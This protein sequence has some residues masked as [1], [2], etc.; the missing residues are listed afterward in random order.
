MKRLEERL[1]KF[2]I[3][4]GLE[5][6]ERL[7]GALG[8]PQDR[9]DVVLVTGTNGKGSV[10][11]ALSSILSRA[12]FRTGAYL[13][14]HISRYNERFLVDGKEIADEDFL[15]YEDMV[16]KLFD[17]GYEM[18]V[19]EALTAIAYRHFADQGC[20]YAVMEIGM[21]GQFD[22]TNVAKE[23]AAI[24]TNVGLEHTKYL[25]GTV[26]EIAR[27]K[28]RIIK[29]PSG[30]AVT[31][32][33]GEALE[34]VRARAENVGLP[35]MALG[36]DFSI[37]LREARTDSTIFDYS[38]RNRYEKLRIALAGKHQAAN[39][40]IRAGLEKTKHKGRLQVVCTAPLVVADGAHNPEG[41]KSLV[42]SLDIYPREKLVCVF[43]ALKDK[44]WRSMLAMLA[45]RCDEMI[46]NQLGGER[47][48]SA[49]EIAVEAEKHTKAAVMKDIAASV[50][51]AKRKAG[52][53]GMVL[54]CGSLYMLGDAIAAARGWG[55]G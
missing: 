19:F 13:S 55:K 32:C 52:K 23:R 41:I 3:M 45:P 17:G 53:R 15:R 46:I 21:G 38:G 40:A 34:E 8:R 44:D 20:R 43:T 11:A 16:L 47:G 4:P 29:N 42:G 26:R 5:R 14:P 37:R 48:A 25:G 7:C 49:Q 30:L 10:V 51:L 36:S 12:G 39:E 35:L 31:G 1:G 6:T 27:D 18:T 50:R 9:M 22:A 2:G 54:I 28:A 33:A 24:I